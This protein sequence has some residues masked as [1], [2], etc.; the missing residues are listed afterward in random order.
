MNRTYFDLKFAPNWAMI[1]PAREF[2]LS[3]LSVAL[4]NREAASQVC[5]AAH[6]LME[7]A[8]KYSADETAHVQLEVSLDGPIVLSVENTIRPEHVEALLAEVHA[9]NE[10]VD[11]FEF[12]QK[13][14]I[15]SLSRPSG[16]AGLGLAR[17]RWESQMTLTCE[18]R[19]GVARVVGTRERALSDDTR[20]NLGR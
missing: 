5:L 8:I 3:F 16:K 6:E 11:P 13:K 12:Y 14:M 20:L 18:V 17:I 19:D 1:E 2:L 15:E 7:N 9:A 10:A 4:D